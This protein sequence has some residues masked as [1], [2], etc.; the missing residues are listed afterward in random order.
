MKPFAW[1]RLLT[2]ILSVMLSISVLMNLS[3]AAVGSIS[4]TVSDSSETPLTGISV[5]LFNFSGGNAG[6]TTTST[7]GNY[8]FNGLSSGLY[9]VQFTNPGMLTTWN[10]GATSRETATPITLNAPDTVTGINAKMTWGATISGNVIDANNT[11]LSEVGVYIYRSSGGYQTSVTTDISGNY[12]VIGLPSGT[13]YIL[14]RYPGVLSIWYGGGATSATATPVTITAPNTTSGIN[15]Q[16]GVG[17][18]I[19]GTVTDGQG[20]P[21]P[22]TGVK[23]YDATGGA[24]DGGYSNA[25]SAGN[26]SISGLSSGSYYILFN[27]SSPDGMPQVWYY[28]SA[29]W[30]G[31]TPI[32][33]NSPEAKTGIDGQLGVGGS[34]SGTVTNTEMTPLG[35]VQVNLYNSEKEYYLYVSTDTSGNYSFRGLASGQYY[36]SYYIFGMPQIWYGGAFNQ[37]AAT[38]ITVTAPSAITGINMQMQPAITGGGGISGTV[39]DSS[40]NPYP[41][42]SVVLYDSTGKEVAGSYATTD[43]S[44]NYAISGLES[45]TYYVQFNVYS[46]GMPPIWYGGTSTQQGATPV[47]VTAPDTTIGIDG[48]LGV[49][50]SISGTVTNPTAIPLYNVYISLYESAGN[51]F[52]GVNTDGLGNYSFQGIPSGMYFIR[53][54]VAGFLPVWYGGAATIQSAM[55]VIVNAQ[56]AVSGI[57]AIM[58]AGGSIR[59]TV[60]DT[61]NSPIAYAKVTLYDSTGS[62]VTSVLS[63]DL[64]NYLVSAIADGTYYLQFSS[65][66]MQPLWYGGAAF[67]QAA[68]SV[69]IIGANSLTGINCQLGIGGSIGGTVYNASGLRADYISVNLFNAEGSHISSTRSDQHGNYLFNG[70]ASGTYY[71]QFSYFTSYQAIWYGGATWQAATPITVT[72]PGAVTGIDVV[73]GGFVDNWVDCEV[74]GNG[75]GTVISAPAGVSCMKDITAEC[76]VPF[77]SNQTVTLSAVP[78]ATSIFSGWS[79]GCWGITSCVL[80]MNSSHYVG[81]IFTEAPRAKIGNKGYASLNFAYFAAC[82]GDEIHVLDAFLAEG[83]VVTE[84]KSIILRG[85]YKAD[86]GSRSENNT[87]LSGS[88]IVQNGMLTVD[89]VTI[90]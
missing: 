29:N 82:T 18:S 7:S 25:D 37:Q 62:L 36:I 60:R 47:T 55:P 68:T 23:L 9:Y 44:G 65:S 50:G 76:S 54:S 26:Y 16:V 8:S 2:F 24:V 31:A 43:W 30:Q 1:N 3:Y 86:F 53:C 78:D 32:T 41:G 5:K 63:D 28:G 90:R 11:P 35:D 79:G 10:G 64:G 13:Y 70:L 57:N 48:Q 49:G 6:A 66:G 88:V 72:A 87:V 73:Y 75:G 46:S 59:G 52:L 34:I 14:F 21:L 67:R 17:G 61:L 45:G 84:D 83:L 40:N 12:S 38:P 39:I 33:V 19:S 81:A 77:A 85:G 22:Y 42:V 74:R 4:G 71:V 27:P 69:T 20:S 58:M 89:S 51:F 15:G 80:D 56:E